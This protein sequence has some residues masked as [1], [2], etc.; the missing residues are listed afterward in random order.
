[1]AG[2]PRCT[3]LVGNL[4]QYIPLYIT[5]VNGG[6]SHCRVEAR[7]KWNVDHPLRI[8][9]VAAVGRSRQGRL[10]NNGG[11]SRSKE[12]TCSEAAIA[13]EP[14]RM[15]TRTE[16]WTHEQITE[17]R[18]AIAPIWRSQMFITSVTSVRSNVRGNNVIQQLRVP[19]SHSRSEAENA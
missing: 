5:V 7:I 2:V 1:M 12:S 19:S 10:Y 4:L 9:D 11:P 14:I 16:N 18:M 3:V 13:S 6:L 17:T 15:H 8:S